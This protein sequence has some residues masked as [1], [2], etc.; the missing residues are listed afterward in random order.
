MTGGD[1]SPKY[2][3]DFD[4]GGRCGLAARQSPDDRL[5]G[6]WNGL[7]DGRRVGLGR[8]ARLDAGATGGITDGSGAWN[9]A[10]QWWNGSAWVGCPLGTRNTSTPR[11]AS[12]RS[13]YSY[14][15]NQEKGT[16]VRSALARP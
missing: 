8:L 7:A 13:N 3:D 11:D 9:A 6:R 2:D 10:D 1:V 15:N 4:D 12:G 16:S 5:V 14:C